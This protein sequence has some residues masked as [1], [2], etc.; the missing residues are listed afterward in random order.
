MEAALSKSSKCKSMKG[1]TSS[2]LA[3]VQTACGELTQTISHGM[4]A[5]MSA[6]VTSL[7]ADVTSATPVDAAAL[8][9]RLGCIV[10]SF[11]L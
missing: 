11:D 3:R 5:Y 10:D 7:I 1:V 9:S 6:Y 4:V 2:Q 8:S